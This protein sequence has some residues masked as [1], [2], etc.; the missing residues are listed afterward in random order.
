MRQSAAALP[1][2]AP[3]V[4]PPYGA[5]CSCESSA[6]EESTVGA[7]KVWDGSTWQTVS[8]QGPA[9]TAPVTSVDTRT[10]AVTLSDLYVSKT[11][12]IVVT[13]DWSGYTPTM[14][15]EGGGSGLTPGVGGYIT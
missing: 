10:G 4:P 8:Q 13:A 3:E 6:Y 14:V 1:T 12:P 7:L 9:G 2:E 15:A 5:R 11:D